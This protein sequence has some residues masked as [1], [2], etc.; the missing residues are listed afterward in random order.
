MFGCGYDK[1]S[2]KHPP[3]IKVVCKGILY[4]ETYTVFAE[5]GAIGGVVKSDYLTDSA[6]FR[7]YIGTYDDEH[8]KYF[9]ELKGDS[10]HVEKIRFEEDL[11]SFDASK[12]KTTITENKT[13]SLK[14]LEKQ[15]V[16]E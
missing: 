6:D 3:Q 5:G 7:I 14:D 16:F 4:I 11:K 2:K 12:I 1:R 10:I 13:Y 15:K 9:Y 8:E